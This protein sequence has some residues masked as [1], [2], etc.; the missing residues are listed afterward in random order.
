MCGVDD[1]DHARTYSLCALHVTLYAIVGHSRD[2]ADACL[3]VMAPE[4]VLADEKMPSTVYVNCPGGF[5]NEKTPSLIV[6]WPVPSMKS[7]PPAM[8]VQANPPTAENLKF[9]TSVPLTTNVT[10]LDCEVNPLQFCGVATC[11]AAADGSG[12]VGAAGFVEQADATNPMSAI[13][14]NG[15]MQHGFI[16]RTDARFYLKMHGGLRPARCERAHDAT[17][18]DLTMRR[19]GAPYDACCEG[20]HDARCC[21]TCDGSAGGGR[22][23]DWSVGSS[24]FGKTLS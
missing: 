11:A 10:V 12:G 2:V 3:T 13:D 5:P 4:A 9:I 18:G 23:A 20:S 6:A 8:D 16:M 24:R 1:H 19:C 17:C 7:S 21:A 14:V 15:T 22:G